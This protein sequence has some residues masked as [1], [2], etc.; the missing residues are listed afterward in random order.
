ML[1]QMRVFPFIFLIVIIVPFSFPPRHNKERTIA[2]QKDVWRHFSMKNVNMTGHDNA[3]N[4]N[5]D[6]LKRA[7]ER[8]VD[9]ARVFE[10]LDYISGDSF[11]S[12]DRFFNRGEGKERY[13]VG[14]K[15]KL[16]SSDCYYTNTNIMVAE[17]HFHC[18]DFPRLFGIVRSPSNAL[19]N[20]NTGRIA[21]IFQNC[22]NHRMVVFHSF[23]RCRTG[24][25]DSKV[26]VNCIVVLAVQCHKYEAFKRT[27]VTF[28][29]R[30]NEP[31]LIE[32]VFQDLYCDFLDF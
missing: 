13:L 7:K 14:R 24:E 26:V 10:T 3:Y 5:S 6:I 8:I 28:V 16:F 31:M 19:K 30:K 29:M 17:E 21:N 4:S 12:R 18:N 11:A 2:F 9:F 32:N 20:C 22:G 25:S 23:E 15:G 27:N 1:K